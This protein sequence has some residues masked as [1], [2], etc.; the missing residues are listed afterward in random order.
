M[1]K[2]V[3]NLSF[4]FPLVQLANKYWAPHVKKTL[5]FD[6]KVIASTEILLGCKRMRINCSLIFQSPVLLIL[7]ESI[8]DCLE[9]QQLLDTL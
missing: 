7:Y 8:G 9:G 4:F 6:V 3:F 1:K 2:Y 5:S